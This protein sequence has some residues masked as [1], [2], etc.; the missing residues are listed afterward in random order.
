L[1]LTHLVQPKLPE[2]FVDRFAGLSP[3]FQAQFGACALFFNI[4]YCRAQRGT[5]ADGDAISDKIET[6]LE[7]DLR[8]FC[9]YTFCHLPLDGRA[10]VAT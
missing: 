7:R 2:I 4:E 1:D 9:G 3:E 5:V 10:G 8:S 6:I